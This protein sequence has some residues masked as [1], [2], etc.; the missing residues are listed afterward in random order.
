MVRF[1]IVSHGYLAD[2]FK[3][4]L[5]IIMG[6]ELADKIHTINAFVNDENEDVKSIIEEYVLSIPLEDK[7]I[8]FSDI[9]HGS[10]NQFLIPLVDDNRIYAITGANFPLICE[11]VARYSFTD[12]SE[13]SME[14]IVETIEKAKDEIILVNKKVKYGSL[15]SMEDDFF[16]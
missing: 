15:E 8:V 5:G 16:G 12:T 14:D 6:K 4:T 9:M 1:L 2:G 7:L 3:S 13:V 11:M 10:V